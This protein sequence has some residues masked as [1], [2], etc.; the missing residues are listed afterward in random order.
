MEIS[1]SQ[2]PVHLGSDGRCFFY[3]LSGS[4][5]VIDVDISLDS[6][7]R[8]EEIHTRVFGCLPLSANGYVRGAIYSNVK[9]FHFACADGTILFGPGEAVEALVMLVEANSAKYSFYDAIA[10]Y[11]P[12]TKLNQERQE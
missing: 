8:I 12:F 5:V 7:I 11:L 6:R 10:C 9:A 4:K 2:Y 1:G 3:V